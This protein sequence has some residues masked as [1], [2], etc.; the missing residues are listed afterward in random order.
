MQENTQEKTPAMDVR[1][2]M[3]AVTRF[4]SGGRRYPTLAFAVAILALTAL[5]THGALDGF[6]GERLNETTV[7]SFV[8][9]GVAMGIDLAISLVPGD[10]LNPVNDVIGQFRQV[11]T[12]SIGSLL[13]QVVVLAFVSSTMFKWMFAIIA[14]VTLATLIIVWLRRSA[15][16]SD[17]DPLNRFC[18]AATRI[19]ILATVVRFIVPVFVLVSYLAGQ[20]LLQ[21][22]ID[23]G[24]AE[25]SAIAED[26][27]GDGQQILDQSEIEETD[28][29][30][31]NGQNSLAEEE[32]GGSI[33]DRIPDILPDWSMPDFDLPDFSSTIP[34]L[35]ERAANLAENLTRLLV[36]FVVK[37]IVLPLVFLAI[38]LKVIK[39]VTMRLLAMTAAIDRD[40]NEIKGEMKQIGN[41]R[42]SRL[43]EPR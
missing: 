24:K 9:Y 14:A 37:N 8:M 7:E 3:R 32:T 13:L 29:A 19:F 28:I 33:F 39:P 25:L 15:A 11:M 23:S 41:R 16:A 30:G 12:W 36:L 42:S 2:P 6:A 10:G 5:S 17:I 21:P 22:E 34:N 38:A 31:P 40:L 35:R 1:N 27:S 20:A 26:T 43:P 4:A 18:R